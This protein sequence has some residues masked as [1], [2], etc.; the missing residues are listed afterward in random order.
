MLGTLL[1]GPGAAAATVDVGPAA[2]D[3][4]AVAYDEQLAAR[5]RAAVAGSG[6]VEEKPMFGGLSFLVD[7][8]LAVAASGQ[9]G[10][11]VR[12]AVDELDDLVRRE[13]VGPMVMGT[14]TSRRWVHVL[15][16]GVHTDE[17]LDE[18]VER[19]LAG[20]RALG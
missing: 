17:Q 14:R 10:L 20:V 3:T 9:G 19:G 6:E 18:W 5:V 16:E 13:H 15:A 4:G 7:G 8:H 12:V 2:G 1:A 11:L